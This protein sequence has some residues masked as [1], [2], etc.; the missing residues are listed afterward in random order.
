MIVGVLLLSRIPGVEFIPPRHAFG[1][2]CRHNNTFH[3]VRRRR[4][5]IVRP[6]DIMPASFAK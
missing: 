5:N 6:L 4:G 3:P 2:L 1:A